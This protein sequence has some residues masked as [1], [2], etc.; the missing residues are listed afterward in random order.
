M[1]KKQQEAI[2]NI[3]RVATQGPRGVCGKWTGKNGNFF[4]F[5]PYYG[6]S[7]S[8]DVPGVLTGTGSEYVESLLE[9]SDGLQSLRVPSIAE[10]RA[11]LKGKR[12]GGRFDQ[13][14]CWDFGKNM[15]MV[16]PWYLIDVLT[17]LPGARLFYDKRDGNLSKVWAVSDAGNG[18][19]MPVRKLNGRI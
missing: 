15:P 11:T 17:I 5:S 4:Y 12:R 10:V 14:V 6:I 3:L 9:I 8:E 18:L 7:I 13:S 16:N 2:D 1:L 19:L